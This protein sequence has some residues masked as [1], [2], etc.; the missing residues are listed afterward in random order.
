MYIM[1]CNLS[2]DRFCLLPLAHS[3]SRNYNG[4]LKKKHP[5]EKNE[6]SQEKQKL[7][8]EKK[9]LPQWKNKSLQEKKERLKEAGNR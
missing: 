4:M 1:Y 9:K 8:Q 2:E 3:G 6:S 5:Q 7:P